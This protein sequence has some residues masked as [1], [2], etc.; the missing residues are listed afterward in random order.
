MGV[1]EM[2][3]TIPMVNVTA[4]VLDQNGRPVQRARIT[5]RLTTVE[6]FC[7]LIIPRETSQ[8]TDADGRA[9][10]RV[11]PNELGTEHSEYMVSILMGDAGCGGCGGQTSVTQH[12]RFYVVVPNVDCNLFDIADLPPYEHRGSGQVITDEVASWAHQAANSAD[13]ARTAAQGAQAAR[14]EFEGLA[15]RADTSA[16]AADNSAKGAAASERRAQAIIDSIDSSVQHFEA[17][18]V[19]RTEKTAQ[20]LTTQ[21]TNCIRQSET[22]ALEAI[23]SKTGEVLTEIATRGAEAQQGAQAAIG[24]AKEK[25]LVALDEKGER[26]FSDFRE[27]AAL[28]G[29]D[30]EALTERAEVSAKRAGC[31]AAS[32]AN[33][34]TKACLCAD[35][36]EKA[37]VGIEKGMEEA[38]A[39]AAQAKSEH[40]CAHADAVCAENAATSAQIDAA[41]AEASAIS[42]EKSAEQADCS[43]KQ[44]CKCARTALEAKEQV[45]EDKA[46][47]DANVPKVIGLLE[48]NREK[49]EELSQ[50]VDGLKDDV[51]HAEDIGHRVENTLSVARGTNCDFSWVLENEGHAGDIIDL[52]VPY[53]VGGNMLRISWGGMLL[54]QN[55]QYREVGNYGDISTQ[56]SLLCPVK[57]GSTLNVWAASPHVTGDLLKCEEKANAI[58][59]SL[60]EAFRQG[61]QILKLTQGKNQDANWIVT[62]EI[63]AGEEVPLPVS[64][65]VGR[66]ALRLFWGGFILNEGVQYEEIG[67]ADSLSRK[68]R[69][70]IDIPKNSLLNAWSVASGANEAE[71]QKQLATVSNLITRAAEAAQKAEEARDR[72]IAAANGVLTG[73]ITTVKDENI[74]ETKPE[75]FFITDPALP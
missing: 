1:S 28:F 19:E 52:P 70:L 47:I 16:R 36:A 75:G 72:A 10:L 42:A 12:K 59:D 43:A 17:S 67:A 31:S 48:N 46:Y 53:M 2:A 20:R 21:A 49:L 40:A 69:L 61:A 6:K 34:A 23:E 41:K 45:A 44:A 3:E 60:E 4:R 65:I 38:L 9:V 11:W 64:Y 39:A 29:A 32:A 24:T 55:I 62:R 18:V 35:R 51:E 68:V 73:T 7:G 13:A 58:I 22:V 74:I 37:A 25:A 54:Y 50:R 57:K 5:M 30:F 33:S 71:L 8:Y 66:A 63:G 26:I 27:E 15:I 56:I 14:D